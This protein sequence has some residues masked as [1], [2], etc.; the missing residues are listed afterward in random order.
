MS[1]EKRYCRT[2]VGVQ[3]TLGDP[4]PARCG[5]PLI[6]TVCPKHG[7][8]RSLLPRH[9]AFPERENHFTDMATIAEDRLLGD[10][11]AE[12]IGDTF[13]N[14]DRQAPTEQWEQ[15]AKAL[16]HHGLRLVLAIPRR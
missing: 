6:G 1:G 11:L 4:I 14:A 16:R 10:Q 8:R 13:V 9:H 3:A 15:I 5:E 2:I 7:I 12:A